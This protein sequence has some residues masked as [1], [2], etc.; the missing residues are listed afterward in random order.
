MTLVVPASRFYA[1]GRYDL[2]KVDAIE[3][4]TNTV[5]SLRLRHG[6]EEQNKPALPFR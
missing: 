6:T 1:L 5:H 3:H 2:R 4:G